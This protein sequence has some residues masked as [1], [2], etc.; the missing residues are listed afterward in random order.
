VTRRSRTL[1]L[2]GV[3]GLSC[4][5][6]LA[7][8]IAYRSPEETLPLSVAPQPVAFSHRVHVGEAGLECLFCHTG[9]DQGDYAELPTAAECMVCHEEIA[10]DS[11]E[12][13]KVAAAA[14]SGGEIPWVPIYRVPDIVFFGHKEHL[15]AGERCATCHGPVGTRDVLQKEVSTSMT[16]CFECHR[17]R[18][19][20]VHCALCH[21]LGH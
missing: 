6:L 13:K 14:E 15:A 18:G 10:A 2:A 11:P 5:V 9:A 7:Q 1:F 16:A 8:T 21:V 12:V 17:E 19:A 20:P 3:S 4:S